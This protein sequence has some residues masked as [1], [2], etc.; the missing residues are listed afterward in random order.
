MAIY[1]LFSGDDGESHF[2]EMDITV[3]PALE[4]IE[5]LKGIFLRKHVSDFQDFHPAPD[6]RWLAVI[7]GAI[8]MEMGNGTSGRFGPG[9]ILRITDTTGRGHKSWWEDDP[10]YA[11]MP[12][13]D[14]A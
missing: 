1:R 13:P 10:V 3:H 11:V 8:R 14:D 12:L 6:K 2:E 4:N 5:A 7:S 9:D